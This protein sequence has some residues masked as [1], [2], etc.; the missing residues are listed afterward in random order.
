MQ[1]SEIKAQKRKRPGVTSGIAGALVLFGLASCQLGGDQRSDAGYAYWSSVD[2]DGSWTTAAEEAVR[3]TSLPE[4]LPADIEAY[5]PRY[6]DLRAEDRVRF[7]VGLLSAM[8]EFESDLD[9][10]TRYTESIRDSQGQPIVSRG[11][12]Q[13]SIESANQARYA[14]RI[15]SAQDLHD[16]STN[17]RCGARILSY[18]VASDQVIAS[19]R[20]EHRGAARYWSVLRSRNR[21]AEEIGGMTSQLPFCAG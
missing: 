15:E 20:G 17:I 12:L 7:W 14:C 8:A 2:A 16:P 10:R 1:A 13:L 21:S 5:C 19:S 18:W 11:L 3:D 6:P 4:S 9:P